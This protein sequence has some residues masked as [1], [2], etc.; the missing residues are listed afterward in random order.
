MEF[1]GACHRAEA[2]LNGTFV[3][4]LEPPNNMDERE[5]NMWE[6]SKIFLEACQYVNTSVKD[7]IQHFISQ[8]EYEGKI[9]AWDER[10]STSPG[11]NMHLGHLKAYWAR[12]TFLPESDEAQELEDKRQA[13]LEG[14]CCF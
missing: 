12:H 13:T 10:T 3:D 7:K 6:L 14:H 9:K 5:Q 1:T 11:T 8:E 4:S 2:M